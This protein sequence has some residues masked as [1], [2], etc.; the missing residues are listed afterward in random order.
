MDGYDSYKSWLGDNQEPGPE[1]LHAGG[2]N[3]QNF[4]DCVRSRKK[5]NLNAPIEEGHMSATLVHLANVS[6]RLGRTL[7][8]DPATQQAVSDD[9]ANKLLCD[10]D[11]GYRA[12]FE[13]PEKV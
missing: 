8:F 5:E 11:R 1:K 6:Y 3:W 13:V 7:K 12:P 4:I 9:E 10:G 2:N